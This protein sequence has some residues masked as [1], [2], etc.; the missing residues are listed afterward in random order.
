MVY[1]YVV[2]VFASEALFVKEIGVKMATTTVPNDE[3]KKDIV[4]SGTVKGCLIEHVN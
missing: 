4:M 3:K 2:H 1:E